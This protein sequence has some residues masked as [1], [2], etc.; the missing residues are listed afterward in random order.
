MLG[1]LFAILAGAVMSVQSVFNTRLSEKTGL[2]ES[3]VVVQG[4]AFAISLLAALFFGKG[5]FSAITQVNRLYLLGGVLGVI[6]TITVMLAVGSLSP[7]VAVSVIL[8]SQLAA[9]AIID[10]LGL[11]GT[12]KKTFCWNQAVGLTLL[13]AGILLFRA[14]F[15]KK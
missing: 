2:L 15:A 1:I 8:V 5:N 11:F 13:V 14:E 12:E 10:L 7:T 3:N 6:I 9:A 4:T